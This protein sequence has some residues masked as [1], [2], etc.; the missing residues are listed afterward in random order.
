M[1]LFKIEIICMAM[2]LAFI[3]CDQVENPAITE[4]A[5]SINGSILHCEPIK[6]EVAGKEIIRPIKHD[7][8]KINNKL[9]KMPKLQ[10]ALG[11]DRI[12]TCKEVSTY[13]ELYPMYLEDDGV[14]KVRPEGV[15]TL[16][17][18]PQNIPIAAKQSSDI[19]LR[20][21]HSN[22]YNPGTV[23]IE[24]DYGGGMINACTGSMINSYSIMT[25]A[26]CLED[27]EGTPFKV[28]YFD[29]DTDTKRVVKNYTTMDLF[30][31]AAYDGDGDW[32]NDIGIMTLKNRNDKWDN[33]SSGDYVRFYNDNLSELNGMTALNFGAGYY[34]RSV[35]DL[36]GE[37]RYMYVTL[38]NYSEHYLYFY[39]PT[40]EYNSGQNC[41]RDSGGPIIP[42]ERDLGRWN[43]VA[44]V[45]AGAD[46]Y[47][48]G[49][50]LL[51][52]QNT[53]VT[54]PASHVGF[55]E[56]SIGKTCR[57]WPTSKGLWYKRCW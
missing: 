12:T 1:K 6:Y 45:L 41:M 54:S 31:P 27:E 26:H 25:A 14:K 4:E 34:D 17:P 11:L 13:R 20:G 40:G 24:M 35:G 18:E 23:L 37:L 51:V 29:P 8:S 57:E 52:G 48:D 32:E 10:S 55:I 56:E 47:A 22:Y 43:V 44:G 38:K 15:L 42:S 9:N 2:G 21:G 46:A 36:D 16:E 5:S 3:G 49:K 28:S 33:T 19:S 7:L 53:K 39:A 50:C 30:I